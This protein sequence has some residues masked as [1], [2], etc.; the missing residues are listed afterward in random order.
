VLQ[1]E[2]TIA[3]VRVLISEKVFIV[4]RETAKGDG[5]TY[6]RFEM[7]GTPRIA[8]TIHGWVVEALPKD[9]AD[10]ATL[11]FFS[12]GADTLNIGDPIL[13]DAVKDSGQLTT[14]RP[15]SV[16]DGGENSTNNARCAED[17]DFIAQALDAIAMLAAENLDSELLFDRS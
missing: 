10:R 16:C 11:K 17:K 14:A 2:E 5:R 9:D 7:D 4:I 1:H 8:D 3:C 15:P 13:S 12:H 6:L